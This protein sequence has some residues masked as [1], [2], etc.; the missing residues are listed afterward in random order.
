MTILDLL[1]FSGG[2]L[3]GHRLRSGLSLLGVAIGVASV[4]VLTSL[5]EGARNYL[6]DQFTSLGTNL[7]IVLPGKTETTGLAPITGGTPRDLTLEDAEAVRREAPHVRTVAPLSFGEAP[8]RYGPRRRDV[9]V[10][11]TTAAFAEARKLVLRL[12]RYLPEEAAR[13]AAPVCVIGPRI[14]RELFGET[15][16]LGEFLRIGEERYRVIGVMAPRGMALGLDMDDIVHVPVRAG[17]RLFDHSGLSRLFIDVSSPDRIEA[18]KAGIAG[19]LR[20]RH[21][22]EEDFTVLTQKSMLASFG[23][24]LLALTSAIAGIAAISLAV[25]GIGIMNVMLVSVSERTAEIGLLRALGASRRQVLTAFLAEAAILSCAGG[26]VGLVTAYALDRIFVAIYPA[27]PVAP[28]AWA[29]AG[30]VLLSLV[31]GVVFGLLPARR[32]AALDPVAA[33]GGG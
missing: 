15:N 5:G 2:A 32:A 25:A 26:L 17:M 1:R 12:G 20:D 29:V 16:P 27:F 21:R 18:A 30:S 3:R 6:T 19:V 31:V 14:Q 33:L 11:G 13:Q 28:P 23:R 7:I 24:I 9:T 10:V 4:I 8:V 22:G